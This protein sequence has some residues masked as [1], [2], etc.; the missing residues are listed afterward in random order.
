MKTKSIYDGITSLVSSL[1]NRRK[2]SARNQITSDRISDY[3]LRQAYI[4]GV[5][6]KII[7]LKTGYA[8]NDTLQFDS[9]TGKQF[10]NSVL[11]KNVK[12]AAKYQ[13]GFGR[14]VIVI[15]EKGADLSTQMTEVPESYRL[16]VFSGDVVTHGEIEKNL[17][18]KN[19]W[20][21]KTFNIYGNVIHN[22]RV[23]DFTYYKPTE[24]DAPE[25]RYGGVSETELVYN[26]LINAGV[27]EDAAA[28][29][30]E[31][32]STPFYKVKDFKSLMQSKQESTLVEYF[33]RIED[34]RSIYGA[35]LL[36]A[37]DS[38]DVLNQSLTNLMDVD[39]ISLRRLA[40]VTGIPLA[41]LVGE[42]VKGL[43]STG[44]EERVAFQDTIENY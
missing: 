3:E 29:I 25:Y 28:S 39:T 26:Q 6:S 33:G 2:A 10:Y 8:L 40:M 15:V 31:K 34:A 20:K 32:N 9:E 44:K 18:S 17:E 7:R 22:S 12:E 24:V 23:V 36:D 37:D 5:M 1:A 27:V 11:A 19:Y 35:G 4:T 13:L 42:N 16:Q 41:L 30:I 14:G 43:N 38:V 21:P